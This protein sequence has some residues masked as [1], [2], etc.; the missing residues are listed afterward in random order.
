MLNPKRRSHLF[1][2]LAFAAASLA[3]SAFADQA[4]LAAQAKV[5]EGVERALKDLIAASKRI[6][7]RP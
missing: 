3:A 6:S 4:P 7:I 5:S 1:T 2:L